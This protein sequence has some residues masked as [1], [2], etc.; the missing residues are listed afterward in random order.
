MARRQLDRREAWDRATH[1]R[2]LATQELLAPSVD[3]A[4]ADPVFAGNLC[5]RQV[6]AKAFADNRQL[7]FCRPGSPALSMG[8]NLNTD[9]TS[10]RTTNRMSA[11]NSV[12]QIR[13]HRVHTYSG[14]QNDRYLPDVTAAT[15]TFYG[16]RGAQIGYIRRFSRDF[17]GAAQVRL[18]ENFRSTSHIPAA[19]NAVIA[20]DHGR[21]GKTLYTRNRMAIASK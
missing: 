3:L 18:E 1:R 14:S 7:L 21:L 12:A 6:R 9:R 5:R 13:H 20:R 19:G 11:L 4:R 8:E 16:W 2:T 17:P 15:L 10:A